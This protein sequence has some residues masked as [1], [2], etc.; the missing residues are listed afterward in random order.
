MLA[1]EPMQSWKFYIVAAIGVA[2]LLATFGVN[3]WLTHFEPFHRQAK[4]YEMLEKKYQ[5][6]S[7]S[8]YDAPEPLPGWLDWM[9]SEQ[10]K[11]KRSKMID[12]HIYYTENFFDISFHDDNIV[13]KRPAVTDEEMRLIGRFPFVEELHLE[14]MEFPTDPMRK[15]LASRRF[16]ELRFSNTNLDDEM[17]ADLPEMPELEHLE[18]DRCRVSEKA[19]LRLFAKTPNL[20]ELR[21]S[22]NAS[23]LGPEAM[24]AIGKLKR[25]EHL[26]LNGNE[27]ITGES[28]AVVSELS[29]L[30]DLNLG[31]C[32]IADD[33]LK[34]LEKLEK[35]VRL[36]L[37][38]CRVTDVGLETLGRFR[39]LRLLELSRTEIT[40]AG[41]K[42]LQNLT[43]PGWLHLSR[44][45]VTDAGLEILGK[46]KSVTCL[47]LDET[48]VTDAGLV[49][50][51][52]LPEL[53]VLQL[54]GTAVTDAGMTRLGKVE[55]LKMLELSRTGIT[56]EGV[57]HLTGLKNLRD[58]AIEE[59][60][61]SDA[62]IDML[63]KMESLQYVPAKGSKASEDRLL[64][65]WADRFP[66][67]SP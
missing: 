45:A 7:S 32:G 16:K 52:H 1:V 24:A 30:E 34:F 27:N 4:V 20:V 62:G 12:I 49:H 50:L 3:V 58:L 15:F 53:T 47:N 65:F 56:D 5:L 19:A 23:S 2:L 35:L 13:Q 63:D 43:E 59:T 11:R 41:L 67:E 6:Y 57:R 21:W 9:V 55:S 25:L 26:Y 38:G 14:H 37:D 8:Y 44:T 40:D 29:V 39:R 33:G 10:A 61:V 42:H 22:R 18:I 46:M 51:Q 17:V 36:Y 66:D 60:P 54:S 48:K 28:L 64:R 31:D